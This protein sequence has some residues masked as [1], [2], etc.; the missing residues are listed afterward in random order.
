MLEDTKIYEAAK[1]PWSISARSLLK[2]LDISLNEI[3]ANTQ[4]IEQAQRRLL[5]ALESIE[6]VSPEHETRSE[7]VELR[8]RG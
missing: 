1:Y 6:P 5:Q 7:F 3:D 2:E 8:L 4:A